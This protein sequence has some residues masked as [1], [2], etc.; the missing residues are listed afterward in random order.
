MTSQRGLYLSLVSC[1][2]FLSVGIVPARAQE[3][4]DAGFGVYGGLLYSI[5][6]AAIG[7]N[8][9][10]VPNCC[11]EF[12]DGTGFGGTLGILWRQPLSRRFA[13][14]LRGGYALISGKMTTEENIGNA[15]EGSTV[16]PATVEHR[17]ESDLGMLTFDPVLAWRPFDSPLQLHAGPTI[18]YLMQ[19]SYA[20]EEALLSPRTVTFQDGSTV[21]NQF[22]GDLDGL[23]SLQLGATLGL[24]Y[25]IPLAREWLIRPEAGYW[26]S[27]TDV[28]DNVDWRI[29]HIRGGFAVLYSPETEPAPPPPPPPPAEVPAERPYLAAQV[30]ASGIDDFGNEA[31]VVQ[32][33]IEEYVS[34]SMRPL[35]PYIFF[36][37][38]SAEIPDRYRLLS[39]TDTA[40]FRVERLHG[41]AELPTYYH[42]LNIV[43]RRMQQR[44][45]A[46]L[47]VTGCNADQEK[48][49][50]AR[51][52]SQQRA[53]AVRQ[54]LVTV[55]GFGAERIRLRDRNLPEYHSSQNTADGSAENRR[56][57]ISC[58]VPDV[59]GPVITRDTLRKATPP[60]IRFTPDVSSDAQVVSWE[61]TASQGGKTLKKFVGKGSLPEFVDWDLQY[62][63]S[64]IPRLETHLE[65]VLEI[66]D[67]QDQRYLATGLPIPVEQITLRKKRSERLADKEIDRY[68]LILF[69]IGSAELKPEQMDLIHQLRSGITLAS[70]VEI[71]GYTDRLGDDESNK[72]LSLKRA[73]AVA[74]EIAAE[75]MTIQ[76]FGEQRLLHENDSPEG[77]FYCRTVTVVVETPVQ[78]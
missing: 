69:E 4:T 31:P 7:Q 11:Q 15:L 59:L 16:V 47:T 17:L 32:S 2:L 9:W 34:T 36:D 8:P 62:D 56:V 19:G 33:R 37:E 77:R 72:T 22:S 75:N 3:A 29:G 63:Q 45:A 20:L 73:Q 26:H 74:R 67:Q 39:G 24:S 25:D 60:M 50:N 46:V 44:P 6:R 57:E 43:A 78:D 53:Q 5:H 40:G 30:R 48:E 1:I 61:L 49:R 21:R 65:Y 38:Q 55:W 71:S 64:A 35:L 76:G 12:S 13:V 68:R 70:T 23:N 10:I 14:E 41:L 28:L 54:Y 58:D 42:V 18:G 52:L 27:F 66:R 51:I